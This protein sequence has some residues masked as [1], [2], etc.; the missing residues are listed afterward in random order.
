MSS[1][2]SNEDPFLSKKHFVLSFLIVGSISPPPVGVDGPLDGH[3]VVVSVVVALLLQHARAALVPVGAG[4]GRVDGG[5]RAG[6]RGDGAAGDGRVGAVGAVLLAGV[7]VAGGRA[8]AAP[9]TAD[10]AGKIS[11]FL[12]C[13]K[14]REC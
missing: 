9:L 5:R 8:G 6:L 1:G 10:L 4:S 3:A 11:L 13:R 12:V 2:R 7:G 14:P